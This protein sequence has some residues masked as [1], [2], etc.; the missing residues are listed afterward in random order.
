MV[1]TAMGLRQSFPTGDLSQ[2]HWPSSAPARPPE[3]QFPQGTRAR[4]EVS[5][6]AAAGGEVCA[7]QSKAHGIWTQK[8]QV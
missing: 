8:A 3:L 5:G 2:G 7:G 6:E 1:A 4:K